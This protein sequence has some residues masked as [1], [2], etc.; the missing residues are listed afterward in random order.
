MC[1]AQSKVGDLFA[2]FFLNLFSVQQEDK[3][4]QLRVACNAHQS[5]YKRAM[6][7]DACDRHLFAMYIVAKF[8]KIDSAF[9]NDALGRPW[10]LST[11]QVR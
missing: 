1:D 4:R 2:L 11:S 9:L 3:I 6:A 8:L 7:G 5:N 10:T